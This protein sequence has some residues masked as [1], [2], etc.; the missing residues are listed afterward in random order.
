MDFQKE[1]KDL[2]GKIRSCIIDEFGH[3]DVLPN[4]FN[5]LKFLQNL[6]SFILIFTEYFILLDLPQSPR[7]E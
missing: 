7:F 1:D 5:I 6:K 3:T 4:N 2:L